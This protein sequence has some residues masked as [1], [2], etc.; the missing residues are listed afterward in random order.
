[1][2]IV[3]ERTGSVVEAYGKICSIDTKKSR[4][5]KKKS[6]KNKGLFK[7]GGLLMVHY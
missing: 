6:R 7:R 5:L 3:V 2:S 4:H 1:M